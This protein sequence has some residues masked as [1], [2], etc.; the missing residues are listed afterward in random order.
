[1][2]HLPKPLSSCL[3]ILKRNEYWRQLRKQWEPLQLLQMSTVAAICTV[4]VALT[5]ASV[6]RSLHLCVC[7][8]PR[9]FGGFAGR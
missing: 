2:L 6:R 7:V 3:M 1:M 9:S 4:S 8:C 5:G